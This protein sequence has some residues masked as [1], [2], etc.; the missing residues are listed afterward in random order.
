M[1]SWTFLNMSEHSWTP[2]AQSETQ[3]VHD[4][5][6]QYLGF[7]IQAFNILA[8]LAPLRRSNSDSQ[9][10]CINIQHTVLVQWYVQSDVMLHPT[11]ATHLS[12]CH[13]YGILGFKPPLPE[14]QAASPSRQFIHGSYH[15]LKGCLPLAASDLL[16][17]L[18]ILQRL[19]PVLLGLRH[20]KGPVRQV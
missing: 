18:S 4:R 1:F 11:P 17:G 20:P 19:A 12:R 16:Q 5:I 13:S 15:F 8:S 6:E 2:L 3:I 10:R 14:I 7:R 9:P